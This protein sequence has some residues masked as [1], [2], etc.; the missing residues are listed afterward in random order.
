[1]KAIWSNAFNLL[2]LLKVNKLKTLTPFH[3]FLH[4]LDLINQNSSPG[5]QIGENKVDYVK[6][7]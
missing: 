1:M 6:Q 4:T 3:L 2:K 7:R 5:V